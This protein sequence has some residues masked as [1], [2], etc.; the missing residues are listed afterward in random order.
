M[1]STIG[2]PTIPEEWDSIPRTHE[3]HHRLNYI[4]KRIGELHRERETCRISDSRWKNDRYYENGENHCLKCKHRQE[5][6]L[7]L[8]QERSTL[9]RE[10][11]DLLALEKATVMRIRD[12]VNRRYKIE[13]LLYA[14]W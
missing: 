7:R 8:R 3:I 4:A 13:K 12:T 5:E 2:S 9:Y 11:C 10:L 6:Q 14:D 1:I